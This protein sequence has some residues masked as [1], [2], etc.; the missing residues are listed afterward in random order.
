MASFVTLK[1]GKTR[2]FICLNGVRTS[3]TFTLKT[4]AK[5]WASRNE[6]EILA[7]ERGDLPDKTFGEL[8]T[9]YRD[10]VSCTKKGAH[11]EEIRINR[12]LGY[13]PKL[14]EFTHAPD[15]IALVK[16]QNLDSTAVSEWRDR[17]LATGVSESSVRREWNQL[18]SACSIAAGEWK[19]LKLNPFS[20]AAGVKRPRNSVHREHTLSPA[21]L[22][23]LQSV[24][25]A[26]EGGSWRRVMLCV[27]F[28]NE[29]AMRAGEMIFLGENP[30]HVNVER[31]VARLP[32]TKN[33]K[34]R[35]V[36]LS[37]EAIRIWT[38]A[39]ENATG[40]SVWGFDSGS[41][42]SAWRK[43]RDETAKTHPEVKRLHFHDTRH[44]AITKLA[45]KLQVLDLARM[46]GHTDLKQLMQYYNEG[47]D[48]IALRL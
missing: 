10:E 35:E 36:A 17:R 47:M 13:S 32:D 16:L 48:S 31:R 23:A 46:T 27:R 3:R 2:A 39:K 21:D 37:A 34:A 25:D 6:S 18:S 8:L 9:R 43:L 5:A 24:A 12:I 29:T 26:R 14:R 20:K 7:G 1:D 42:D 40:G 45:K 19:W 30:Q 38:Q 44:T 15:P 4:E 22:E 41:L 33:G 28:C 11:W